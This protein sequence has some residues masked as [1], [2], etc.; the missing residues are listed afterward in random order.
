M[1]TSGA[2]GA[3]GGGL[4]MK[5]PR[6]QAPNSAPVERIYPR[7]GRE[8]RLVYQIRSVCAASK[9]VPLIY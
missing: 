9:T 4:G 7:G 5:I 3:G 8:A 6:R 2:W 1:R